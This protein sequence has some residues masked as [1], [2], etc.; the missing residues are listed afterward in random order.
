MINLR[1]RWKI[2]KQF[3]QFIN[4]NCINHT[5]DYSRVWICPAE[6]KTLRIRRSIIIQKNTSHIHADKFF[7]NIIKS[8]SNQIV[9]TIFRL[10]WIQADS[11]W[12]QIN[13][14]LVNTI[15]FRFDSTKFR[16][17]LFGACLQIKT[18]ADR[19]D[20]INCSRPITTKWISKK[21]QKKMS[22]LQQRSF[23]GTKNFQILCRE[24]LQM[25][26]GRN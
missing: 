18:R 16:E 14:K 15:W 26:R 6:R 8:N 22:E 25:I 17:K 24:T 11:V 2:A 9:F 3:Y 19:S 23:S 4:I 20:A 21:L 10:I 5:A 1:L 12:F 13:R 7:W